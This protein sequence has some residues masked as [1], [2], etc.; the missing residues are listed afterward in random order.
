MKRDATDLVYW[1]CRQQKLSLIDTPSHITFRWYMKNAKKDL[2]NVCFAKKF[3]LDGLVRAGIL[4]DDSQ[5]YVR[6][7]TDYFF[8]DAS[9]PHIEVVLTSV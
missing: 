5:K 3:I 6:G 9:C 2:D 4:Y 8:I 7:F 1:E